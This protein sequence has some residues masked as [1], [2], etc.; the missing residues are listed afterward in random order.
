MNKQLIEL[1]ELRKQ[2][3]AVDTLLINC[4]AKRQEIVQEIAE[5]K[6]KENLAIFCPERELAML[7][8]RKSLALQ[9]DLD[10]E[11]IDDIFQTILE[12]S[13]KVQEEAW[14]SA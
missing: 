13:R 14:K 6:K 9:L 3:D 10:S 4:L 2:I 5:I 8:K 1:D 11:F 12:N 7:E